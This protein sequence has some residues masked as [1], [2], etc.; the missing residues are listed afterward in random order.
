[1]RASGSRLGHKVFSSKPTVISAIFLFDAGPPMYCAKLIVKFRKSCL[2][3]NRATTGTVPVPNTL[4][5]HPKGAYHCLG[6]ARRGHKLKLLLN[7]SNTDSC[8]GVAPD[9]AGRCM[10]SLSCE[11][12]VPKFVS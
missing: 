3:S 2:V 1:M 7:C 11:S 4:L 6:A 8:E 12:K 5:N 10:E 9:K